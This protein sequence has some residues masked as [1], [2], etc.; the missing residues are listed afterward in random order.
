MENSPHNQPPN[1]G[2]AQSEIHWP[3]VL[4]LGFSLLG[5]SILWSVAFVLVLVGVFQLLLPS[6][7]QGDSAIPLLL[8]SSGVMVGLL[9][10]PSAVY[11]LLRLLGRQPKRLAPTPPWLRPSLSIF[12][13]PALLL[14]GWWI[15]QQSPPLQL[16][17]PVFHILAIGI[18][19]LW[20]SYLALR[21]LPLGSP[22]RLWGLIGSGSALAP[23]LILIAE[24][25]VLLGGALIWAIWASGQPGMLDELS[26]LVER[27]RRAGNSPQLIAHILTPYLENPLVIFSAFAFTAVMVPL[28]EEAIKPLGVWFLAGSRPAPG[29]GFAAGVL[30]GA[31]YALVES[32]T[33]SIDSGDQ[34]VSLV[35]ARIGTAV[36]HILTSGLTGWA[37]AY[38]WRDR[39]Y[40][41]LGA[42]YLGVVLLHGLWNGLTVLIVVGD[43]SQS[44]SQ[45]GGDLISQASQI[46]PYGLAGLA[47]AGL[48]ALLWVNMRLRRA[49]DFP[50]VVV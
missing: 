31:G 10:V 24:M 23:L 39:R 4:Q 42:T 7:E 41:R 16:L 5:I 46:A 32:L 47:V 36:V 30:C 22:Q 6:Q 28:I 12:A 9:L 43:L 3:S 20:L 27:L 1:L 17:L 38:A 37:L 48:A 14:G 2:R 44:L 33:L 15:S 26:I 11:S 50:R 35:F 45:L 8:G 29:E 49:L 18:P 19:I 13:L 25:L 21:D 40:L 34:W